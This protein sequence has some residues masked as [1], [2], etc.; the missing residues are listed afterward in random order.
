M[1][2]K[3]TIRQVLSGRDAIFTKITSSRYHHEKAFVSASNDHLFVV[4]GV[5]GTGDNG[6]HKSVELLDLASGLESDEWKWTTK[7]SYPFAHHLSMAPILAHSDGSFYHFGGMM[8]LKKGD[9]KIMSPF[10]ASY[11]PVTN[12][13][14][15]RGE[16][17]HAR[18][19]SSV[20]WT[21]SAFLVMGGGLHGMPDHEPTQNPPERAEKCEFNGSNKFVCTLQKLESTSRPF[22]LI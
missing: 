17:K 20:I 2:S 22:I 16:L 5:Y 4:G 15:M 3:G 7:A 10:I 1:L 6:Q 8:K 19:T 14:T 11:S 21:E 12:E 13:W 9:D 18:S